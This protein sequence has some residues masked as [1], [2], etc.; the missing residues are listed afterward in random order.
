MPFCVVKVILL[1]SKS[2]PF[3]SQKDNF[4]SIEGL[5]STF[6]SR[7]IGITN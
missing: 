2:Y 5:F 3:G 4:C 1:K 7:V 6:V